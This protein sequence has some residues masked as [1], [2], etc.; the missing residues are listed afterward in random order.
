M[1]CFVEY[2]KKGQKNIKSKKTFYRGFQ[3]NLIDV[4]ELLKNRSF[5]ITFPYFVSIITN[6]H[7]VEISSKRN[8]PDNVRKAKGFYSVI[9]KI[10]YS[11]DDGYEPCIIDLTDLSHYP[12]DK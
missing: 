1:Y 9:M 3:L 7:F 10:N 4:L 5:K 2:G 11:F 6:K 12:D 8:I